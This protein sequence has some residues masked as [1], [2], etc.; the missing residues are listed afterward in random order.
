MRS[1]L[2][3]LALALLGPGCTVPLTRPPAASPVIASAGLTHAEI[4]AVFIQLD[5]SRNNAVDLA[6]WQ[7]A[8]NT[9]FEQLDS[10]RDG[11]LT[12]DEIGRSVLMREMFPQ[13]DRLSDGR[14][15]RAEFGR[16]R[17]AIF[18]LADIRRNAYINFAEYELLVLLR[19]SGWEDQSGYGRILPG[20]LHTLLEKSL[21]LLDRNSDGVLTGDELAFF[22]PAHLKAMDPK[23]AGRV[24]LEQI[25]KGYRWLI[26]FD[27][28]NHNL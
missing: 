13:A 15:A 6:E 14:L 16:L 12:R 17:D 7:A 3:S 19:R 21:P 23:S 24:T 25:Y 2:F 1:F 10:D 9:R 27:I 20:G 18:R 4:S 22:A 28:V 11:F 26:G 8:G 5:T